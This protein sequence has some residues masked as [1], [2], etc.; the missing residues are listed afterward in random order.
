MDPINTL[1]QLDEAIDQLDEVQSWIDHARLAAPTN[2][3]VQQ[4]LD[5]QQAEVNRK[6]LWIAVVMV[7]IRSRN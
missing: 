4:E 1:I 7:D 6:R 5:R 3:H 2:L